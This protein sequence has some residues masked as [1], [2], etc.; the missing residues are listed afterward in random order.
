MKKRDIYRKRYRIKYGG[1]G[2]LRDD[3]SDSFLLTHYDDTPGHVVSLNA[4]QNNFGDYIKIT[5]F[6]AL[7]VFIIVMIATKKWKMP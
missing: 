6:I 5:I 7:I 2:Y 4:T 3:G 1:E